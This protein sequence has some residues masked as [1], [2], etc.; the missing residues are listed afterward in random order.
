MTTMATVDPKVGWEPIIGDMPIDHP[1]GQVTDDGFEFCINNYC[2]CRSVAEYL[3][4]TA[5]ALTKA[6]R[7]AARQLPKPLKQAHTWWKAQCVF[8]GLPPKGTIVQLQERLRG[9]EKAPISKD[10][11]V[12]QEQAK[13]DYIAK[14]NAAIED[15]WMHKLSSEEKADIDVVDGC[16]TRELSSG[17]ESTDYIGRRTETQGGRPA[18]KRRNQEGKKNSCGEEEAR[19]EKGHGEVQGLAGMLL[20]RTRSAVHISRRIGTTTREKN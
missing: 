14:N 18:T 16:W 15:S 20:E 13:K 17:R 5:L 4:N 19:P 9:H 3:P 1:D 10:F 7:I 8:R 11:M 6:R 2:Y 12:I